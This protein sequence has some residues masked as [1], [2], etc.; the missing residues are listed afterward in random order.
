MLSDIAGTAG[1]SAQCCVT[2]DYVGKWG[3]K[4]SRCNTPISGIQKTCVSQENPNAHKCATSFT[5]FHNLQTLQR[6]HERKKM[7]SHHWTLGDKRNNHRIT[8]IKILLFICCNHFLAYTG[9]V[10]GI[11]ILRYGSRLHWSETGLHLTLPDEAKSYLLQFRA[12]LF[13]EE[14]K[15]RESGVLQN[16]QCGMNLIYLMISKRDPPWHSSL[17]CFSWML[18]R[19]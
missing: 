18:W 2:Q 16:Y 7:L 9:N 15:G 4:E 1:D 8:S 14:A 12:F 10:T 11:P 19:R 3:N 6:M 5:S 13:E 17:S